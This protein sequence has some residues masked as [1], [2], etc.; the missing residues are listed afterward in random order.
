[1]TGVQTCA[2]PIWV[3]VTATDGRTGES[4]AR[5]FSRQGDTDLTDRYTH[6]QKLALR[7]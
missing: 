6:L 4:V 3:S 1:M 7:A 2:L 5:D